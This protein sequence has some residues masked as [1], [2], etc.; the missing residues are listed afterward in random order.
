MPIPV[1]IIINNIILK[2]SDQYISTTKI[3]CQSSILVPGIVSMQWTF[4]IKK[5][6][7]KL[8]AINKCLERTIL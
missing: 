8:N 3:K 1:Q 5:K 4:D 2:L 7:A 6:I